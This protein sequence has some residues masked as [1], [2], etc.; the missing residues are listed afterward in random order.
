MDMLQSL[1]LQAPLGILDMCALALSVIFKP[2]GPGL[3]PSLASTLT[4]I[5]TGPTS[6]IL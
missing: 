5:P 2:L 6:E 3:E 1:L 4:T